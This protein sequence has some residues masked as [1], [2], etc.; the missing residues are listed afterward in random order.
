MKYAGSIS[1]LLGP[2]AVGLVT[3]DP[4]MGFVAGAIYCVGLGV[5][6]FG[7]LVNQ[8]AAYLDDTSRQRLE[9]ESSFRVS[10]AISLLREVQAGEFDGDQYRQQLLREIAETVTAV[11]PDR[12]ARI[13]ACLLLER[14]GS[15][16]L[17]SWSD[18]R[19]GRIPSASLPL[20]T[21]FGAGLT[22]RTSKTQYLPDVRNVEASS[23]EGKSYRAILSIPVRLGPRTLGV[24]SVDSTAAGHFDTVLVDLEVH[25]RP[26]VELI[27]LSLADPKPGA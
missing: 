13:L 17:V 3:W 19:E 23:F 16:E 7:P 27:G 11:A 22:Y 8:G 10:A 26:F 15:L 14:S 20:S 4:T 5:S 21:E 2:V 1:G 25:V 6:F 9:R 12:E 18:H 24:V